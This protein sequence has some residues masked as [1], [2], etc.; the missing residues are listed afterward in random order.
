MQTTLERL[1]IYIYKYLL[2]R[3]RRGN[4]KLSIP[5]PFLSSLKNGEEDK[6]STV[7]S[8]I[9]AIK[10][11]RGK[12]RAKICGVFME[13]RIGQLQ[14]AANRGVKNVEPGLCG[15]LIA[16]NFYLTLMSATFWEGGDRGR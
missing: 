12:A 2:G 7:A 6:I 14:L 16:R 1:R 8:C 9:V 4:G 3:A 10:G 5:S 13:P 11:E 15:P